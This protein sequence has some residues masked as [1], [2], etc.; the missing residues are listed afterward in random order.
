MSLSGG[1]VSPFTNWVTAARNIQAAI[2]VASDGDTILVTNGI[3]NA[4]GVASVHGRMTNRIASRK[5][6]QSEA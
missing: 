5:P 2:D 3:Y 4:G 6:S 1:H